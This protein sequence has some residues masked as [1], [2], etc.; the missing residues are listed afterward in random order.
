[1]HVAISSGHGNE[2][3][4]WADLRSSSNLEAATMNIIPFRLFSPSKVSL[5]EVF[6]GQILPDLIQ[7]NRSKDT[8]QSYQRALRAWAAW[9]IYRRSTAKM[10]KSG[11]WTTYPVA[12][13]AD[14]I[15]RDDVRGFQAWLSQRSSGR[16]TNKVVAAIESILRQ[17]DRPPAKVQPL[18]QRNS[19]PKLYLSFAEPNEWKKLYAACSAADWPTRARSSGES[20]C[21]PAQ[22]RA[23]VVLFLLYG[24]RTE[25]LIG[26]TSAGAL[27]ALRWRNIS[28]GSESPSP[29]SR[30]QNE[31]GW[32]WYVPAKQSWSKPTP[33][34]LPLHRSARDHLR[35]IKPRRALTESPVFDWPYC[36]REFYR[37]WRAIVAR[38]G[39][40]EKRDLQTGSTLSLLPK[41]LR[42]SCVTFHNFHRPGVAGM[43]TGHGKRDIVADHYDNPELTLIDHF[44]TL[45]VPSNWCTS[46]AKQLELFE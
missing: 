30:A 5:D 22:W 10:G 35:S 37:C 34:V 44:K 9:E 36:S 16:S 15:T 33:I 20:L 32:L 3:W 27:A 21:A 38:A 14:A 12:K 45:P 31:F 4:T 39:I 8:I 19:S 42:K 11:Y 41:H 2:L 18:P 40:R 25:E 23:A 29:E 46:S 24:F 1:M 7:R 28:F 43:I 17:I 26:H 6:R 13:A